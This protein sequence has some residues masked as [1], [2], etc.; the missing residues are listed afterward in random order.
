MALSARM[1]EKS[2]AVAQRWL[3][4][5]L[6]VYAAD[7]AA[8]FQRQQDRFANPVGHALRVGRCAAVE[9]I[10]EGREPGEVCSHLDEIIK[11]RAVQEFKPSEAI[12][13]VFLLKEAF[14]AELG[15][16][17]AAGAL[18]SELAELDRRID[19]IALGAFDIYMHYRGQ[20]CE[21]RIAEVKRNVG[22]LM[23]RIERWPLA[24]R[25]DPSQLGPLE[26]DAAKRGGGA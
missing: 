18:S 15:R 21:L 12:G 17:N 23:E 14:G 22:K 16:Q 13:F 9:A 24:T 2:S 20:V 19:L 4:D 3:A 7:S 10:V 5:A 26:C 6:A 25:D 8:A 1:R 11:I